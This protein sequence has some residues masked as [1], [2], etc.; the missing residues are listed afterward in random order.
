M[1]GKWIF[2]P[3]LFLQVTCTRYLVSGQRDS[4]A[5][6]VS[7]NKLP[8]RPP[9]DTS[10][11]TKHWL[12]TLVDVHVISADVKEP[13]RTIEWMFNSIA[14][15]CVV[16]AFDAF[17]DD[18]WE[19]VEVQLFQH[20]KIKHKKKINFRWYTL[21]SLIVRCSTNHANHSM[22]LFCSEKAGLL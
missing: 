13:S 4:W 22:V 14:S 20:W 19:T 21:F 16:V 7:V 17:K 9:P 15:K 6:G 3:T 10:Q 18:R 2:G 8:M 5:S 1:N 11:V 12:G